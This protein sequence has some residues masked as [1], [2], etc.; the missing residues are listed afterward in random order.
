MLIKMQHL[1]LKEPIIGYK[2]RCLMAKDALAAHSNA[3]QK[4][5]SPA[6]ASPSPSFASLTHFD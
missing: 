4:S 1:V 3:Q 6:I 5:S 2:L